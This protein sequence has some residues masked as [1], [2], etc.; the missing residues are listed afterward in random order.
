M[1]ESEMIMTWSMHSS[2]IKCMSHVSRSANVA[3]NVRILFVPNTSETQII[4]P[5]WCVQ[6]YAIGNRTQPQMHI[7]YFPCILHVGSTR[8]PQIC[9]N[10]PQDDLMRNRYPMIRPRLCTASSSWLLLL[11]LDHTINGPPESP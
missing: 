9:V 6:A 5:V 8:R 2:V 10:K 7:H 3:V 11:L 4:Y 1:H